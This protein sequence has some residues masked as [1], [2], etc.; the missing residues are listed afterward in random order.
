MYRNLGSRAGNWQMERVCVCQGL[1]EWS[2]VSRRMNGE[3]KK[4]AWPSQKQKGSSP[5]ASD[6]VHIVDCFL[7]TWT[8]AKP[9]ELVLL[10]TS[11]YYSIRPFKQENLGTRPG[12][13]AELW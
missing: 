10:L 12:C 13:D 5:Q 3:K 8:L 2:E 7:M 6:R 4:S 11:S 9:A 1:V